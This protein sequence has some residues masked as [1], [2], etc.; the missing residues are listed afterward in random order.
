MKNEAMKA[1]N[2]TKCIKKLAIIARLTPRTL[3]NFAAGKR[4]LSPEQVAS[5]VAA[6]KREEFHT[7]K[8]KAR[9]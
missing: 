9:R 5:I 8:I 4:K 3:L 6:G 2:K 1:V 7:G